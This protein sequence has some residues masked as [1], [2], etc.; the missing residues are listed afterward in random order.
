MTPDSLQALERLRD[1]SMLQW[2]VIPLFVLVIYI[3]VSEMHNKNWSAVY[4][5]LAFW[6]GEFIWE[7]FNASILHFSGYAPLWATP[8]GGSAFI[9]YVGL[10]IEIA[11]FFSIAAIII[12]KS[13]PQD[14]NLKI[15]GIPNRIVIPIAWGFFC[16]FV[17]VLLNFAGLLTWNWAFWKWPHIWLIVVAY[18]TPWLAVAWC[19][20]NLDMQAKKRA[21]L[22]FPAAAVVCHIVFAN[23]LKWV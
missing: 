19:H 15:A 3:Y 9:I 16:V 10:N 23:I 18:C 8:G 2:Y 21:A 6:G 20:D 4:L 7:M 12:I 11:L 1:P 5:G 17:E 14:K 22:L 13:L